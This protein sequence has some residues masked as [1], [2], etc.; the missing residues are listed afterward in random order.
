[1]YTYIKHSLK[2]G[3]SATIGGMTVIEAI[4]LGLLQGLTEFI[5]VSSSGHLVIGQYFFSGASDH[6]F[7]E[8]INLGTLLALVIFFRKRLIEIFLDITK[9]KN[10]RLLRNI[11]ITA[12]PAGVIGFIFADFIAE[13]PFFNSIITVLCTLVVVGIL[14]VVLDKLPILSSVKSGEKLP[15]GRALIVGLVQIFALIPG[16]SRSGSTIIAGRVM[17]LNAREAAEYSFLASLPIMCGVTLKLL[18]SSTDRQ[19]FID[20]A[21]MLLLSNGVA[22]VSGWLAVGF[23]MNYLS[24]HSL[25]AFGWYRIGL[26]AVVALIL[27]VQ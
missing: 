19:Y 22:F 6:L 3:V 25:A 11:L 20:H 13:T 27:L 4:V 23:L 14:M 5:P 18:A 17:G 26:A 1:M 21:G 12:I 15:A 8:W 9:K 24:R 7:L 16:V 10:T 2:Q